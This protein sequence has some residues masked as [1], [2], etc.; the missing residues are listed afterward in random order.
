MKKYSLLLVVLG[1]IILSGCRTVASRYGLVDGVL[2]EVERI[3][4]RG[5]GK[6]KAD[7]TKEKAKIENDSGIK[8]PDFPKIE[9]EL[10]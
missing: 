4:I 7:F 10:D 1:C 8:I 3:E 2:T 6:N 9:L 5:V